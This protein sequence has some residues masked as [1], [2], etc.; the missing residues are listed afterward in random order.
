MS[1]AVAVVFVLLF[2]IFILAAFV[3]LL[4]PR[5]FRNRKTGAVPG[6]LKV[7]GYCLALGFVSVVVAGVMAPPPEESEADVAA[8]VAAE[9]RQAR[10]AAEAAAAAEE[11]RRAEEE[12]QA[13][14]AAAAEAKQLAEAEACRNDLQCWADKHFIPATTRCS[15]QIE[16]LAQYQHR[17]TD[18][19]LEMKLSR[20]RWLDQEKGTLT[21]FGDKIQFQNGFGAWQNYIYQC[22]YEPES[23]SVLAVDAAPG[24]F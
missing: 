11:A 16:R 23:R 8:R 1:E 17:W 3:G 9:E 24:R 15:R 21:Y 19:F 14:A 5:L 6:R 2:L 22:D 18:G 12:S 4:F 20:F 10:Q 7:F 13:A